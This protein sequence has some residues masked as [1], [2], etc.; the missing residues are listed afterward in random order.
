MGLGLGETFAWFSSGHK[1]LSV[2]NPFFS[3]ETHQGFFVLIMIGGVRFLHLKREC[4][5]VIHLVSLAHLPFVYQV[6]WRQ[7]E[8][9]LMV[10]L[11]HQC[12]VQVSFTQWGKAKWIDETHFFIFRSF[13]S[14][15]CLGCPNSICG[16]PSSQPKKSFGLLGQKQLTKLEKICTDSGQE[17]CKSSLGALK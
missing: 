11:T 12:L 13:R 9:S 7:R 6:E 15:I 16:F 5:S 3:G 1:G 2:D 10:W 8:L 17:S 14:R 4:L